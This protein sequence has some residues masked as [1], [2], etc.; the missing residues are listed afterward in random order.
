MQENDL[1]MVNDIHLMFVPNDLLTKN[2]NARVGIYFHMA[3]PSSDVLKSFPHHQE[4]L[5]SVLLCDVI[6]FHVYSLAH[7]FMTSCKR[8]FGIFYKIKFKGFI[9]FDYLGRVIIIHIMHAG[10]DTDYIKSVISTESFKNKRKEFSELVNGKY[11]LV[12][13]DVYSES[14]GILHKLEAYNR[15]LGSHDNVRNK[16]ILVQLIHKNIEDGNFDQQIEDQVNI[17][18]KEI[19]EQ[20]GNN[21]LKLIEVKKPSIAERLALFSVGSCILYLQMREG[22]C[23]VRIINYLLL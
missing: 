13:Q 10:L 3:F 19:T 21:V 4:L 14:S 20:Y 2:S 17:L 22:N 18:V 23:M 6:G 11:S 7:N 8:I 12:S 1:I 9:T 15:F 16:I 5:K